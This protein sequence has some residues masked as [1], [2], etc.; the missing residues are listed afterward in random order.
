[1]ETT[2]TVVVSAALALALST[3]GPPPVA[4]TSRVIASHQLPPNI[5]TTDDLRPIIEGLLARS[6]TLRHQSA[7][8]AVAKQTYVSVTLSVA[9]L[10]WD[11]RARSTA[12]R[13][14]S[15][16]LVVDI[17]IPPASG[18]FPELLAHELEH[19]T[20]FIDRIDFK[21]LARANNTG[22]VHCSGDGSFET[23]RAQQAGR[24]VKIE[25][26]MTGNGRR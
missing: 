22:V 19:A 9:Q 20:E 11:A 23:V 25:I 16:L 13:Y 12:R 26:E 24:T 17:E 2:V 5:R 10:A 6:A 3:F 4:F 21:K 18:D 8:I 15:G 14:K 7:R 1:V